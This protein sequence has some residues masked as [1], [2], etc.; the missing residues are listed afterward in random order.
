MGD[1]VALIAERLDRPLRV[2]HQPDQPGD[3]PLTFADI[4][5]ACEELGYHP[6]T[7]I[8]EGR[9]RF[10]AWYQREVLSDNGPFGGEVAAI[11]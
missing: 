7:P 4:T 5:R 6:C 9:D 1:L 2:N 8:T 3:V 11:A 10:V